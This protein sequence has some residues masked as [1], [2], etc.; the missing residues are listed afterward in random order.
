MSTKQKVLVIG[1]AALLVALFVVAVGVGGGRERGDPEKPS[2]LVEWLGSFGARKSAVDP[3]TVTADCAK[4]GRAYTFNG[5]CT[6]HVS[7]PGGLRILILRSSKPFEVSAPAPG[8]A[9]FTVEKA[10]EPSPGVRAEAK[11][12]VDRATDVELACPGLGTTCTVTV[13]PE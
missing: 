13:E 5:S 3:A 9:D 11:I 7:D 6:L 8:D 1:L 2:G 4:K 10:I 12:A